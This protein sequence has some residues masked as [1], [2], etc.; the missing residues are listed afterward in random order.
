MKKIIGGIV[1]VLVISGVIFG[2]SKG[3]D[4]TTI[5]NLG[6]DKYYLKTTEE[7]K[8]HIRGTIYEYEINGYDKNGNEKLI[9][10]TSNKLLEKDKY[11]KVFIKDDNVKSYE[12]IPE[13]E[14]PDKVKS[15][16]GTK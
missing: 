11:L 6:A 13:N 3:F 14:L 7:Y 5:L 9:T 8:Q 1:V 4:R 15:A 12:E 2:V 10:F 16:Y